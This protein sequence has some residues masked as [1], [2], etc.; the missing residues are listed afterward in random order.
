MP[1]EA[2]VESFPLSSRLRFGIAAC[3]VA[4][5]IVGLIGFSISGATAYYRTPAEMKAGSYRANQRIRVAGVVARDTVVRNGAVTTFTIQDA[6]KQRSVLRVR[7][8]VP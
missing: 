7:R 5:A 3:V 1:H 6:A 8:P 2:P 4:L